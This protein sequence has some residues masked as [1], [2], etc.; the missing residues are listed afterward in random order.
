MLLCCF[1][2]SFHPVADDDALQVM[3]A[4]RQLHELSAF[5]IPAHEGQTMGCK[6]WAE[7]Y[8]NEGTVGLNWRLLRSEPLVSVMANCTVKLNRIVLKSAVAQTLTL[9]TQFEQSSPAFVKVNLKKF[10]TTN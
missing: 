2:L 1:E 10:Q 8:T 3:D 4:C 6:R 7:D 9:A 5:I